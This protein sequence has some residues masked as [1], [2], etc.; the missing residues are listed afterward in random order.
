LRTGLACLDEPGGDIIERV[1]KYNVYNV[2]NWV[3]VQKREVKQ[4]LSLWRRALLVFVIAGM[5]L[6]AGVMLLAYIEGKRLGWEVIRID[7]SGEPI[8]FT[9]LSPK[10]TSPAGE[11]AADYY[12]D[13]M[14]QV[15]P[16]ELPGLTKLNTFYRVNMA[17]LPPS[18][19]PA[20]L[21]KMVAQNLAKA[22]PVLAKF[23]M[24]AELDL[25]GFDIGILQGNQICKSRLDSVQS[26]FFLLSLRTLDAI[27][28][29]DSEKAVKSI[30]S[31]L[32]L[33]RIFDCQPTMFVQLSKIVCVQLACSDVLLL[34]T[35]CRP[36]EQQ[37]ARLGPLVE[38]MFPSG[39][40]ESML[41]AERVYQLEIARNLI[42][43][44]VA[45]KYL[46]VNPPALP[47]RLKLPDFTWHRMRLRTTAVKYL[48]DMAWFLEASRQPW[49]APL[50]RISDVNS[51]PSKS[52][53]L[54]SALIP[55]SRLTAE[56]LAIVRCTTAAIAV[57][58]YRLQKGTLPDSL[59]AIY[60]QYV[61]SIPLDPFTA[62]PLLF[63]QDGDSYTIYSAGLNRMDDKG[64]VALKQ[65][66]VILD[67]GIRVKRS[68]AEGAR[69]R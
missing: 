68:L 12:V 66:Q 46:M 2:F 33:M 53:R 52:P 61:K 21:K 13:A 43:K 19:F 64:A 47:E 54:A 40:L 16:G 57:E 44:N 9:N 41:L 10:Q 58:R 11:D 39:S 56:T 5:V 37:L 45:S 48:R 24:G 18:Q 63:I 6:V 62:R 31:T 42:P 34:L 60:P 15:Q 17:A 35:R 59:D 3:S 69:Q 14:W 20:D 50:D 65:N 27:A 23:D 51:S 28:A 22:Q 36:S 1:A 32:K 30:E 4:P 55:L 7:K 38:G 29:N 8:T 67:T 49:P 26:A 25:T